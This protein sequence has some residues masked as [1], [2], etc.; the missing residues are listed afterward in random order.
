MSRKADLPNWKAYGDFHYGPGYRAMKGGKYITFTDKE[1]AVEYANSLRNQGLEDVHISKDTHG[2]G[3]W[4]IH[5][6]DPR[7]GGPHGGY[8]GGYH[9][10]YDKDLRNKL[11]EI[12]LE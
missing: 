11:G 12:E 2:K 1:Q 7:M 6:G 9:D 8:I 4:F 10:S 3:R 5:V